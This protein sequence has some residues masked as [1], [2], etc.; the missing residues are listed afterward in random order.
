MSMAS[1]SALIVD[2]SAVTRKVAERMLRECGVS[3]VKTTNNGLEGLEAIKS[4]RPDVVLL[5]LQMPIMDG[6]EVLANADAQCPPVILCSSSDEKTLN[7]AR[8][9]GSLR[10]IRIIGILE[11]PYTEAALKMLLNRVGDELTNKSDKVIPVL[12]ERLILEKFKDFVSLVFQP[13]VSI[14]GGKLEGVEALV[15]WRGEAGALLPPSIFLPIL[16]NSGNI[17]VLTQLVVQRAI[18]TLVTWNAAG[19]DTN[20]SINVSALDVESLNFVEFVTKAAEAQGVVPNKITLEVTETKVAADIG[21]MLANL[22]RLRLRGFGLSIDDFGCGT[23]SLQQLRQAPFTELKIDR[24]FTQNLTKDPQNNAI[25]ETCIELGAKLG[26][27][28]VAEGVETQE[29]MNRLCEMGCK[30]VQGY[31]TARPMQSDEFMDWYVRSLASFQ[32]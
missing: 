11:K 15:R 17:G 8:E 14:K 23:S 12:D 20:V 6:I 24:Q 5:D 27:S 16:E 18:E 3:N 29:D 25:V 22:T 32:G 2:D 1:R 30:T 13:K 7:S 26:L 10:G 28:V 9:V 19:I 4:M 31:F 21:K